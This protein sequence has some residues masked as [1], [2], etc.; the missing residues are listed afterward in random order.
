MSSAL[1]EDGVVRVLL[2]SFTDG[3]GARHVYG[4]GKALRRQERGRIGIAPRGLRP[5]WQGRAPGSPNAMRKSVVL[6]WPQVGCL[7]ARSG[8]FAPQPSSVCSSCGIPRHA[9]AC[10]SSE[11]EFERGFDAGCVLYDWACPSIRRVAIATPT[12]ETRRSMTNK[13][14]ATA[15]DTDRQ[16]VLDV[17]AGVYEAWEA[18]DAEAFA[19]DYFD[20]ASVVQ[21]GIYKK[22]RQEIQSTMAGG[23]AGPLKGSRVIDQPQDVRFPNEDTAIVISEGG[24]VF[25]GSNAVPSEGMVRATWVLAK[26]DGRW[27]V[28]AYHHSPAN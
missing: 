28:A 23:F 20:D 18:N 16:A 26:R 22:D 17:L 9:S 10:E 14:L 24:I 4:L 7:S 21:P 19:A 6:T 1:G 27:Y 5:T 13:T 15:S 12:R 25:P 8:E 11:A 2:L 3:F